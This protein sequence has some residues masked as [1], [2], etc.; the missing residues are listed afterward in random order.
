MLDYYHGQ[1]KMF[2]LLIIENY[3]L[4]L[5]LIYHFAKMMIVKVGGLLINFGAHFVQR[6]QLDLLEVKLLKIKFL[7]MWQSYFDT[8]KVNSEMAELAFVFRKIEILQ[9]NFQIIPLVL[10]IYSGKQSVEVRK[11]K[12]TT[13]LFPFLALPLLSFNSTDVLPSVVF[14]SSTYHSLVTLTSL[15]CY[16]SQA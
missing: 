3:R 13:L 16:L 6:F 2:D 7:A 10:E 14:D 9:V 4:I 5:L 12:E 15:T 1:M 11:C 8:A